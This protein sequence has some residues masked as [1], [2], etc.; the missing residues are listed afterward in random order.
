M[1]TRGTGCSPDRLLARVEGARLTGFQVLAL[2]FDGTLTEGDR[3]D[4]AVLE[5]VRQSRRAGR[6]VVL[7]T[8]RI[9][10]EL[11]AVFPEVEAEFDAVVAE[12]GAVIA[13]G[14]DV[15]DVAAPI[16]PALGNALAHRDI[17]FRS[18]RVIV[19]CEAEHAPV[20]LAEVGRLG[21]DC[22][23]VRNRAAL[24]VLPSGV[25]KGTGLIEVLGELGVSRHC[26]LAVGDAENDLPLLEVCEVGV[27]VANGVDSLRQRADIVLGEPDG[28]GIV[29][30]LRGAVVSG[31]Q[32][33]PTLRRRLELGSATDGSP[34]SLPTSQL[35]LLVTGGSGAGKSYLVGML[36]EQLVGL[37]YAVLVVDLEGDHI[38]LGSRRG[39]VVL[40]GT[41]DPPSPADVIALLDDRFGS[42]VLD[43]SLVEEQA[44][45]GYLERLLPAVHE[46][47]AACGSPH[48][49]VLDEAHAALGAAGPD[50]LGRPPPGGGQ[51]LATHRPQDLPATVQVRLDAAVLLPGEGQGAADALATAA[52]WF[53]QPTE[54]TE[55]LDGLAFGHAV[56]VGD[57]GRPPVTFQVG[58]RL[59][60]HVRHWHKYTDAHLSDEHAFRFGPD[61]RDGVARNVR[62]FHRG[63]RRVTEATLTAHA[64]RRDLS[65]WVEEIL[66]ARHLAAAI[67]SLE[68]DLTL[69]RRP[70]TAVRTDLLRAIEVHYLERIPPRDPEQRLA[71]Q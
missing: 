40:G 21:L 29:A 16:D 31:E 17:A 30:L 25:T 23:L 34:V 39:I 55:Q 35:T 32:R 24:M 43:L 67:R 20:V 14:G 36:V 49:L 48:W 28:D 7:V 68:S 71:G 50:H 13:T 54:L 70:A 22:Q 61:G 44:Q 37:R 4:A 27:A 46:L 8:G 15:T 5:A 53:G 56:L 42:V 51:L 11:R 33:V 58:R 47:Q 60:E 10:A 57:D 19:A 26:A 1:D 41:R 52:G 62:E 69:E 63:L 66:Q 64:R 12:N 65:R 45:V 3:P 18:G 9:L 59:V 2:D 6:R 38:G